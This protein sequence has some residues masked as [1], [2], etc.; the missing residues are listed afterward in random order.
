MPRVGRARSSAVAVALCVWVGGTAAQQLAEVFQGE[1]IEAFLEEGRIRSMSSLSEG[2]TG[3]SRA[4]LERDGVT[5]D[6]VF[7]DIEYLRPGITQLSDASVIFNMEDNWRFEVAAYR[8][9]RLIGLGLV[10][11]TLEREYRGKTGSLQWWVQSEM[12]ESERRRQNRTPPDRESWNRQWSNAMLF[13]NLLYNWDRHGNNTLI[14]S[15]F[16]IRLIDH[17]RAFLSYDQLRRPNELTR[18]SRSL[19]AGLERL[20]R[21]LLREHVGRYLEASKIDALLK[22]RDAILALAKQAVAE[23]GEA[24]VLFP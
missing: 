5:H 15:D 21:D 12:S 7:K 11:A 17:S 14:T 6:A 2:I 10:P 16:Q 19:L 22:R 13:D 20:N 8:I 1:A 24:E 9:D 3:P 18:F 23:R 4:T